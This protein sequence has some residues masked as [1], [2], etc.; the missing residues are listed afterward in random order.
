MPEDSTSTALLIDIA[1][2]PAR[3]DVTIRGELDAHSAVQFEQEAA[4]ALADRDDLETMVLDLAGITFIDSSGLRALLRL[5][6]TCD[7]R[8]GI[9]FVRRPSDVVSRIIDLAKLG[10]RFPTEPA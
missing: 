4:E 10:G 3:I 6:E 9:L 1:E 2:G 8:G 7:E 5:Q